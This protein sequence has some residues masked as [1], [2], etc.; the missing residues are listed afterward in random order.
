MTP[1]PDL[2]EG[3]A[4]GTVDTPIGPLYVETTAAGVVRVGYRAGPTLAGSGPAA[5]HLADAVG[6]IDDYFAGRRTEFSVPLDWSTTTG[7]R[8]EV[9]RRVRQVPYG[10]VASYGEVAVMA[11]RPGAARAVG[12]TMANNP[13]PIFI[14]C[15]RVIRSGGELGNYGDDPQLKVWLLVHEGY[16]DPD[17]DD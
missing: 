13:L 10:E 12:T 9:L 7:F 2:V 17:D 3:S 6:E 11:G 8:A 4:A 5:A 16:L 14:P 15:H 1:T